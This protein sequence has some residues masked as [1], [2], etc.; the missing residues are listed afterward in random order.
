[1]RKPTRFQVPLA[2]SIVF[3]IDARENRRENGREDGRGDEE[4][5]LRR[6]EETPFLEQGHESFFFGGGIYGLPYL[7]A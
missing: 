4:G 3:A 1:M 7:S 2:I 6:R 5:K